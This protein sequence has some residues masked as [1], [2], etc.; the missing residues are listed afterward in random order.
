[1]KMAKLISVL[2]AVFLINFF[3]VN[4]QNWQ[5]V[6]SGRIAYF[7]NDQGWINCI[8]IDSVKFDKDSVLYPMANIQ[9]IGSNC[10]TP[11]GN[12]WMGIK[13]IIKNNG[14][15][16][17]FNNNNDTIRINTRAKAGESWTLFE[18]KDS[19]K[20]I[21]EVLSAETQSILGETDSIKTIGFK[22]Y[23]KNILAEHHYLRDK[24]L[25]LSKSHGFIKMMNFR[26]FPEEPTTPS[27][28]I[29]MV[30]HLIGLTNPDRGVQNL[31]IMD[32]FDFQVGDELHVFYEWKDWDS[33]RGYLTQRK[34][35]LK[36]L[37]RSGT[38]D[39]VV[40]KID[41]EESV[42]NRIQK[43]D[44]TT[45][46]YVHDTLN[47]AY[48]PDSLFDKLPGEPIIAEDG[49]YANIMVNG[50]P[51]SKIKPFEHIYF[52][53]SDN[54]YRRIFYDGCY[55]DNSYFKG[56]GGPY[57]S[58][59]GGFIT[60]TSEENKLVYYKKGSTTWGTP[61]VI[62]AVDDLEIEDQLK[63]YPNPAS[64]FVTIEN[65]SGKADEYIISLTDLQ[66]REV[67]KNETVIST[68][69]RLDVS[70]LKAGAYILKLKDKENQLSRMIVKKP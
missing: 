58:C 28:E 3:T 67:F 9:Q 65:R 68:T 43:W 39:S 46:E 8:R 51:V 45:Y 63:V 35:I 17:F 29:L 13:V 57:Y 2:L 41:R 53:E 16:L 64:D 55:S 23:E 52:N 34:T 24:S 30:Y 42:F 6:R 1:M 18:I 44:S 31:T 5:T 49:A 19:I 70:S 54:C 14:V 56:L 20:I 59:Q 69:F 21:A 25:I 60:L 22:V 12:S 10:F 15:N 7:D 61:L 48:Q 37:E 66:G 33:F 50:T 27:F 32:I 36:Y 38:H 62:T 11:K 47:M 40:Y 4:G 26:V